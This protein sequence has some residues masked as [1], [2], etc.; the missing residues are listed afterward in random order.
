MC[1]SASAVDILLH[2]IHIP[3]Y[4]FIPLNVDWLNHIPVICKVVAGRLFR[5]MLG[6]S[7]CIPNQSILSYPKA[8]TLQTIKHLLA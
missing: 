3:F 6:V 2:C 7:H 8:K 5:L 1:T 4:A